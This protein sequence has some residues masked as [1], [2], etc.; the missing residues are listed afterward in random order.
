MAQDTETITTKIRDYVSRNFLFSDHGFDYPDDASF[1]EEGIIDSLGI[2]ELVSFVEKEFG[3]AVADQELL[4]SNF[5]SVNK[6]GAFING[7]LV[8][9][10]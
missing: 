10:S 8:S 1:L 7:K 2:I 5:D 9:A 3:I 4:P 6:L